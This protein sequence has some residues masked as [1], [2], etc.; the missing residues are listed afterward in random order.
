[1]SKTAALFSGQGSQYPG[2]G[3]ELYENFSEVRKLYTI[4]GEILG[5]D[6]AEI[7]FDG[8]EEQL[9]DTLYA[10][11]AIF[12][13]SVAAFTAANLQI[14]G[15][16]PA[17]VAG[18]SLGE[19]AALCC[20]GAFD[21]ADGFRVIKARA[22]SMS[23]AGDAKTCA[24]YAIMGSDV[25]A[26]NKACEESGGFVVPVNFNQPS[27]TVI[28]GEAQAAAYA[29]ETLTEGGAKAIKLNVSGA[30]HTKMMQEA[31]DSLKAKIAGIT[32]SKTKLPF[33]SNLTGS[34]LEID[35]Y[36]DY[37]ARHMVSPVRFSE[38]IQNMAA[39]G[40]DTCVEFGPK[41]TAAMLAK[42]NVKALSVLG[43]EDMASLKK[44]EGLY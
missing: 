38:Q 42:K 15:F 40:V 35:D 25:D 37:F 24:M 27:Q 21:A 2:M 6:L 19:Y 9:S 33:Y 11:P 30:F 20:A 16:Q 4:G 7:S 26:I 3:R 23:R 44:L 31:A 17:C 14:P 13:L 8:S 5:Y 1:M 43:I 32:F 28:S 12:A 41:R 34:L 10:Q 36:P 39:A 22:E 29:A 18:H